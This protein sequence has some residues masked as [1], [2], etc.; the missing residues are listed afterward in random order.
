MLNSLGM[1]DTLKTAIDKMLARS[2]KPAPSVA[3]NSDNERM[4]IDIVKAAGGG[5]DK[6]GCPDFGVFGKDFRLK[7]AVE[8]K[9]DGQG[10]QENQL[11]M[12]VGLASLGVPSFVWSPSEVVQI[13]E[14]GT[15]QSV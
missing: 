15:T 3:L 1:R 7:A 2:L 10:P 5:I 12:L 6:I 9:R 14:S 13:S 8:V 4:F 11:L